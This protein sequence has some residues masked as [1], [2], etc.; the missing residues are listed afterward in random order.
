MPRGMVRHDERSCNNDIFAPS[1]RARPCVKEKWGSV[2][3]VP[4]ASL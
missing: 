3:T 4:G 2:R 1:G